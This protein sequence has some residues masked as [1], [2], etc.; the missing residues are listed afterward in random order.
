VVESRILES[1]GYGIEDKV[2]AAVR[3]WRF[4]PATK[5]GVAIASR[6]DVFHFPT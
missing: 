4:R 6:Q 3:N 2:L 5:D 1:L